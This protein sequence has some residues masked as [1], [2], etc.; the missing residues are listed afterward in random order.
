VRNSCASGIA[1]TMKRAWRHHEEVITD[2]VR[3][4]IHSY[5]QLPVNFYQIQFKFRDEIRPSSGH[6]LPG[7]HHEDGYTFDVDEAGAD[8]SYEIMRQT[9]S[10]IFQRCG[11]KF[12]SLT[13]IQEASAGAFLRNTCSRR[14]RR[15]PDRHLLEMRI[16][17]QHGKG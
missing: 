14:Y 6:A 17:S 9:Y 12:R 1:T 8:K 7:V 4:E 5:K 3:R 16:R 2:L 10:S 15:G 11:L 13:R